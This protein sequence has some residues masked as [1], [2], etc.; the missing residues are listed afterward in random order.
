MNRIGNTTHAEWVE[1]IDK[2]AEWMQVHG[3]DSPAIRAYARVLRSWP[4]SVLGRSVG[5]A[6]W[7]LG[8]SR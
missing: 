3:I 4:M 5:W 1:A 2:A 8:G 6:L 7:K